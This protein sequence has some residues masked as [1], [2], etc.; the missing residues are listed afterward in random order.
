MLKNSFFGVSFLLLLLTANL[1]E[2]RADWTY[3]Q[4]TGQLSHNGEAIGNG[5]SGIKEGLNNPEKESVRNVG[6]IP[7]GE[8]KIGDSFKHDT[9]GPVVMRLTPVGHTAHER[10]AFLIHGD[11]KN[12]NNTASNGCIIL[13]R[14]L[15]EKIAA[16]GDH[17]LQVVK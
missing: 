13:S 14:K 3:R 4:S 2:L 17:T 11:N 15:R 7:H 5:Y 8:W 9:K 16:S 10:T 6:P 12:L 1:G